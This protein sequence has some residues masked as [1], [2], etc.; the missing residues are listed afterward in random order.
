MWKLVSFVQIQYS[1]RCH[2]LGILEPCV[3]YD[4]SRY[5]LNKIWFVLYFDRI[6]YVYFV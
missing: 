6:N 3:R 1:S 4:F 2:K 5:N